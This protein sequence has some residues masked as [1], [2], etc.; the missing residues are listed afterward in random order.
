MALCTSRWHSV[1]IVAAVITFLFAVFHSTDV[2]QDAWNRVKP[3]QSGG[4][5]SAQSPQANRPTF[6]DIAKASGTDKVKEHDYQYMYD[7]YLPAFRD[8]NPKMLE[9]GLGCDMQYG[10]GKSYKT[11]LDYFPKVN[12]FFME[13]DAKCAEKWAASTNGATI[14]AGDQADVPTLQKFMVDHGKDFDIIIDDGG[15]TMNQQITSLVNLWA[16]VKPGGIYFLEDLQTSFM[17]GMYG[18]KA[19]GSGDRTGTM[20]EYIY[21]L[22]DDKMASQD[23]H[24]GI[25]STLRSIDCMREVCAFVKKEVGEK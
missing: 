23:T 21:A 5:P 13:Y 19:F 12:L 11:W 16:A 24:G 8:K 1:L 9:I 15:H 14:V 3:A 4:N 25:S 20:M 2:G 18:G 17:P 6:Y 10:P 22:I 7:K